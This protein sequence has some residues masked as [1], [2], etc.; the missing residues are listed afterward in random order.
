MCRDAIFYR[1]KDYQDSDS[2]YYVQRLL[3]ARFGTWLA[4][5]F[6]GFLVPRLIPQAM[7]VPVEV[8]NGGVPPIEEANMVGAPK[9]MNSIF[10]THTHKIL[11]QRRQPYTAVP[12]R[13]FR[14]SSLLCDDWLFF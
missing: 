3:L 2:S 9:L 14:Q 7:S 10:H 6:A 12:T 13:S 11:A 1:Q 5:Y 8:S 4:T